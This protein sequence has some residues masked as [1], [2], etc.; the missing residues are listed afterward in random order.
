MQTPLAVIFVM[1]KYER[2]TT[3]NLRKHLVK[4]KIYLKAEDCTLLDKLKFPANS[5]SLF[6]CLL[7]TA[8]V[9]TN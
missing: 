6:Y 7:L 8:P 3:S 5:K 9:I 4:H 2:W 1:Q